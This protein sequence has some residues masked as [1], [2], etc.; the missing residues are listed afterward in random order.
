M[1]V[2]GKKA[3]KQVL[4]NNSAVNI[5]S[6]AEIIKKIAAIESEL[7]ASTWKD[8]ETHGKFT[9][10]DKLTFISDDTLIVGCDVGSEKHYVRAIDFRGRELGSKAYAF[11]N[12]ADGFK[13]AKKWALDIAA[14][15]GKSQ[16]ILGLEPTGHY[17]FCLASWMIS[18]GISVVQVNPYA[19]KQTK[20]IEDNSQ[21]KDDRKD[22]KV[23]ANL[24]KNGNYG[25][26]Y[27]PEGAYAAIR[28]LT[29]FRDQL[30]EDR[31]RYINRLHREMKIYFPEYMKAFGILDGDF[32]LEILKKAP[33]PADILQLGTGGLKEIW[34]KAGFR[35][36]GYGKAERILMYA[37]TSVGLRQGTEGGKEAVRWFAEKILELDAKL[38]ETEG[39][40]QQKCL[41]IPNANNLLEIRGIGKNI[42]AGIL[43]EI[44][45]IS[46]FD[47]VKELQKLSGLSIVANDSGKHVGETR[48]SH[49]GRKRL[50]YWLFQA[51]KSTVA[52]AEE[53]R[54]LHEYYTTRQTNPL[55]KMQSLIVISCKIL[56]VVFTIL[57]TGCTYD[58]RKMLNDIHRPEKMTAA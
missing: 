54:S 1:N 17:W 27:L 43:S 51:A 36:A 40:V 8:L 49:R 4:N 34:H 50:R 14:R 29:M 26:P 52:H 57:K 39:A 33:F 44:G 47:N 23:I 45:D 28:R 16:I 3:K 55:K 35:G 15:N 48:I 37:K 46:R 2:K 53:F 21:N 18:N 31:I 11:S 41:E 38:A 20:E 5:F 56:R 24:V 32:T 25:T 12:D 58:P 9:K 10:N 19:V 42:Q 7:K 30:T 13:S 22:P 6:Q